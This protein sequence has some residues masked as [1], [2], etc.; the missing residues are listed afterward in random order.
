[1]ESANASLYSSYT[2]YDDI[3]VSLIAE[4]ARTYTQIRTF[5]Q[6]ITFARQNAKIQEKALE[7]ATAR[8]EDGEDSELDA[9]QAKALLKSTQA[10]I[11]QF[12]A[13]GRQSKN[14]LAVLLGLP[15]VEIQAILGPPKDIPTAHLW[16]LAWVFPRNSC[17]EGPIFVGRNLM[18]LPKA[19]ALVLPR[20]ICYLGFL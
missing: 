6:R 1:M 13:G 9:A 7:L 11:P 12:Q 14:A 2:S 10:A 20:R 8:Y 16:K 18:R 5:E 19:R 4:V 15:P 17:G 3:L